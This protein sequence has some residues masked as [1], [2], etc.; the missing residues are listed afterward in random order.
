M[1][2]VYPS[3]QG[4]TLHSRAALKLFP[5][6]VLLQFTTESG[7][8]CACQFRINGKH[9]AKGSQS[10]NNTGEPSRLPTSFI[11]HSLI[12]LGAPTFIEVTITC[13]FLGWALLVAESARLSSSSNRAVISSERHSWRWIRKRSSP[14]SSSSDI[15]LGVISLAVIPEPCCFF[16]HIFIETYKRKDDFVAISILKSG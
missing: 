8:G 1:H 7:Q 10:Y 13:F 16:C 14:A 9:I 6:S 5:F 2:A 4:Y 3:M 11:I 15:I 12:V